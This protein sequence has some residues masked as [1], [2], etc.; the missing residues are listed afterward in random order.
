MADFNLKLRNALIKGMETI[1]ST[2]SGIASNAR[3]RVDEMNLQSKRR[4]L[5]KS[6]A[7]TV[8]ELYKEGAEFPEKVAELLREIDGLD[9]QVRS[10]RAEFI[11]RVT[12]E[13]I[14][15]KT[16]ET[17]NE[18]GEAVDE[19]FE[20]CAQKAAKY[21]EKADEAVQELSEAVEEMNTTIHEYLEKP[22]NQD[23]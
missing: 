17:L 7:D 5:M 2:A 14:L 19:A 15:E 16:E 11:D 20:A 10:M 23:Q 8:Y 4:E 13:G 9:E 3:F 22:D 12:P 21:G 6:L 18:A 1:G